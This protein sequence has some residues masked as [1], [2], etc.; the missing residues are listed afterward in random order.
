MIVVDASVVAKCY[1][2]EEGSEVADALLR[3]GRPLMAPDII[4]QEV[5]SA[6][7]K[8]HRLN[9]LAAANTRIAL[10]QWLAHMDERLIQFIPARGLLEDATL[11]ALQLKHPLYDCL[12]LSLAVRERCPLVTADVRLCE[13]ANGIHGSVR[14]LGEAL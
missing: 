5:A 12:Y 9:L 7:L 8:Q 10:E 1:L 11:L 4:Q 2:P 13:R 14:L 6:I 3:S